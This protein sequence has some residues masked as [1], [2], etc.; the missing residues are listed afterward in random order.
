MGNLEGDDRIKLAEIKVET[1]YIKAQVDDI[2]RIVGEDYVTKAEFDPVRRLVF[3]LVGLIM[4]AVVGALLAL[5]VRPL[6]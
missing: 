6:A 5:I 3:G 1:G 2:K 4:I